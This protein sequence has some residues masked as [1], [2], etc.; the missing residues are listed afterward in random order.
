MHH[1]GTVWSRC[2]TR[3]LFGQGAQL[4]RC[5]AEVHHW[6]TVWPRRTIGALFGRG[7]LLGHCLAEVHNSGT[8]WSRCTIRALFGRGAQLGHCLA[9]VHHWGSVWSRCTIGALFGRGAQLGLIYFWSRHG[10]PSFPDLLTGVA[11]GRASCATLSLSCHLC[12]N[13]NILVGLLEH[14]RNG[15][16][17]PLD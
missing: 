11:P 13:N 10:R 7:A 5:L 14:L 1:W 4:G 8:V 3:A 12:L 9:E 16:Q 6:G 15:H 2:T 17:W